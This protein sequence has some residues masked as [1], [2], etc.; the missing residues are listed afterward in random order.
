MK[1]TANQLAKMLNGVVEGDGDVAVS[2]PSKIEEGK[3]G[4]LSF[5][6]NPKYTQYIYTTEASIVI[7][8]KDFKPEQ[9]VKSTLIRVADA[10][11]AFAQLLDVYSKMTQNV[12]GISGDSVISKSA[13]IGKEVYI[14]AL[15]YIGDN[16]EIGDNVK[17]YPQV[18]VGDNVKIG[19]NTT[20]Y[21]G[22]KIYND[23]KIGKRCIFHSGVVIGSDGF[24]FAPQEGIYRKIAQVGNVLIEDD[25]EIG[26]NTAIDRATMGSTVI[27]K[28]VKIDNLV[29]IAHNVEIG[30]NSVIIGQ[31]GISGS[32]KIGKNC[33]IAGQAGII[34]HLNIGDNVKIAA[35]SGISTN[36]KDGDIVMGSPAFEI[37]RYRKSY[38]HFR[39]LDKHIGRL[40]KLEKDKNAENN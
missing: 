39:N 27:R 7:V 21:A 17:I 11:G 38:I 35:Q 28:G 6:A 30:E 13:T 31:A 14:G 24:G 3:P 16:A 22:V 29:Q 36:L 2:A 15:A 5:L 34:G 18:Y 32:T 25:V 19:D 10:Y 12:T 9:P 20:I 23:S 4:T 37:S 26:A 33:V 40:D 1:F 8:D